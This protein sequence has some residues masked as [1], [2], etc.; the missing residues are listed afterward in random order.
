MSVRYPEP[1]EEPNQPGDTAKRIVVFLFGTGFAAVGV[2][3]VLE[4]AY[5][6]AVLFGAP[7]LIFLG[8]AGWGGRRSVGRA[9]AVTDITNL[10]P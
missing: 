6:F 7:A 2:A 1:Q 3:A 8:I 5:G 9:K 10:I 4:A